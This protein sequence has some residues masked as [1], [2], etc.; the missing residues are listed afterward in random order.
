M[1]K[2]SIF[3]VTLALVVSIFSQYTFCYAQDSSYE[4]NMQ[5]T[6]DKVGRISGSVDT[7]GEM[8][9]ISVLVY[10][11]GKKGTTITLSNINDVVLYQNVVYT[12]YNGNF[13]L[14]IDLSG[15]DAA[16]YDMLIRFPGMSDVV[17]TRICNTIYFGE[18]GHIYNNY[19]DIPIYINLKRE[20]SQADGVSVSMK[21]TDSTGVY[22]SVI[23]LSKNFTFD[24]D[25][26]I[27]GVIHC[28]LSNEYMKYGVMKLET[29]I[30]E[31]DTKKVY[32]DEFTVIP[33]IE[34]LNMNL[35]TQAH[36]N[37]MHADADK[38]TLLELVAKAG[39]GRFRT[40]YYWEDV[41]SPKGT[42][43]IEKYGMSNFYDICQE[44]G[45]EPLTTVHGSHKDY[46]QTLSDGQGGVLPDNP[47][48]S[49]TA[50]KG[51]ANFCYEFA[52]IVKD[53]NK[54]Y[55]LWNE[56]T[57]EF[58]NAKE[59]ELYPSGEYYAKLLKESY[60][61]IH[62]ADPNA[63]VYGIVSGGIDKWDNDKYGYCPYDWIESV[64]KALKQLAEEAGTPDAKYMDYICL[65]AYDHTY[66]PEYH[67]YDTK[68]E[69][70]MEMIS[71]Y[72]YGDVPVV[73]SE[74]GVSERRSGEE[75]DWTLYQQSFL[76]I[77]SLALR[78]KVAERIYWYVFMEKDEQMTGDPEIDNLKLYEHSLGMIRTYNDDI[79]T[80]AGEIA[81]GGKPI[82]VAMANWNRLLGNAKFESETIHKYYSYWQ[83]KN[84]IYQHK[85]IDREGREVNILWCRGSND[86][87]VG[88]E[89]SIT[90]NFGAKKVTRYD[91]YG[92]SEE[93]TSDTGSYSIPVTVAPIYIVT[94][95]DAELSFTNSSNQEVKEI[96]N[97]T[98][99][100]AN[101]SINWNK[102]SSGDAQLV[103]AT[104]KE[105]RLL[106]CEIEP[107]V[108][109]KDSYSVPMNTSEADRINMF[110]W[111]S[112][113]SMTPIKGIE[114]RK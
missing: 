21:I 60:E 107:V 22:D 59:N 43:T 96:G 7:D 40:G 81:Y 28:D 29:T 93:L 52:K 11:P 49:E 113:S 44:L 1:K 39:F 18:A 103:V 88:T 31:G 89:R 84:D 94:P 79:A 55:D 80:E 56:Y 46:M 102:W 58:S 35:G 13:K 95:N 87:A 61:K 12:E 57:H 75:T 108:Q 36:F 37:H 110:V 73:Y 33:Y 27:N 54:S 24:S 4:L 23:T 42:F 6:E 97:N 3:I 20:N 86:G 17:E 83:S 104:Y 101:L 69:E 63:E 65:H 16:Y 114:I 77:R 14:D 76:A 99:V 30:Q 90:L 53:K 47:P 5:I 85:Y 112:M 109:S 51:F 70:L 50:I 78:S 48:R 32:N 66:I 106:S 34:E 10:K 111:N 26:W 41:E 82:Y 72:G 25:G 64:F 100:N 71:K 9:P 91:L 15:Y 105:G 38:R 62:E 19:S 98:T 92:N 2:R 45:I 67:S 74:M 8:L 68:T